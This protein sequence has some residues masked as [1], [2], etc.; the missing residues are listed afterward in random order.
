V[1]SGVF[2]ITQI[3]DSGAWTAG[4][5]R[6]GWLDDVDTF[7]NWGPDYPKGMVDGNPAKGEV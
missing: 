7:S 1:S 2:S 6:A 5:G 4:Y 3:T